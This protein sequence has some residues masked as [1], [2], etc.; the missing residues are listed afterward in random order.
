MS[1][2][3]LIEHSLLATF[4]LPVAKALR[5]RGVDAMQILEDVGI[6]PAGMVRP[7]WRI[8]HDLFN[9]L[10]RSAVEATEDEA[11]GLYAAEQLRL[12]GWQA[13]RCTM[14]CAAWCA[15]AN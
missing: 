4:I 14:V 12:P 13:T 1:E 2:T 5:L 3:P 10:M 9:E 6:D 8:S 11:F 7:D 15:S